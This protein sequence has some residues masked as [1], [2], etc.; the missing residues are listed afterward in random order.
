MIHREA[1]KTDV[2]AIQKAQEVQHDDERRDASGDLPDDAALQRG[3]V[4]WKD[5]GN[6]HDCLLRL[7]A[8]HERSGYGYVVRA[9]R[10]GQRFPAWLRLL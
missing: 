6:A 1:R 5:F 10:G 2:D 3:I 9:S 4:L 7:R 8:A